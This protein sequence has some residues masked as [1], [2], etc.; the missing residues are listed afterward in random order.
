[1][2]DDWLIDDDE[3]WGEEYED[4]VIATGVG[5]CP[6]CGD[7]I[8]EEAEMCPSCGYWLTTAERHKLWDG[9]SRSSD[10]FSTGKI[11]LVIILVVLLL[12]SL[13]G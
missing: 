6:E 3:S 8:D 9:A 5:E 4:Y 7:E 1:M 11:L 12:R 2:S 13:F 10:F